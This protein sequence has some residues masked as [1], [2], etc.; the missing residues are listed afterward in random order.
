MSAPG[1]AGRR[2]A[3]GRAGRAAFLGGVLGLLLGLAAPALPAA[4]HAYLVDSDP[5]AEAVLPAAPERVTLEFSE[6]VRLV[7]DGI[8]VL[9]PDGQRVDREAPEVRDG[10]VTVPLPGDVPQGTFLV[11]YRVISADGHPVSGALTY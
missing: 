10:V 4:A 7:P 8:R 2:R 6:P 9:G 11:S 5:A 3:G 1:W